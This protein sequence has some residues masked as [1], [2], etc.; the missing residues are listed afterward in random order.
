MRRDVKRGWGGC[1]LG[2]RSDG[3]SL[4]M[5]RFILWQTGVL[6]QVASNQGKPSRGVG[7]GCVTLDW[8]KTQRDKSALGWKAAGVPVGGPG[9]EAPVTASKIVR[10]FLFPMVHFNLGRFL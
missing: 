1:V 8:A 7:G 4:E 2:N 9:G 5:L 6:P 10:P 3:T